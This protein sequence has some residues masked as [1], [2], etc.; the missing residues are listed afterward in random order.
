M[1]RWRFIS[2]S[3]RQ[4]TTQ[5]VRHFWPGAKNKFV[6]ISKSQSKPFLKQYC[7]FTENEYHFLSHDEKISKL[8]NTAQKHNKNIL[9]VNMNTNILYS[10]SSASRQPTSRFIFNKFTNNQSDVSNC[11]SQQQPPPCDVVSYSSISISNKAYTQSSLSEMSS[12]SCSSMVRV[13]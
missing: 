10:Q 7:K 1:Y 13:I 6:P 5:G 12:C 4:T 8:I 9:N 11:S 3:L 2:K